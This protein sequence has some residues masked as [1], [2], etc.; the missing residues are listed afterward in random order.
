M[1]QTEQLGIR[2]ETTRIEDAERRARAAEAMTDELQQLSYPQKSTLSD[3]LI[4]L[5]AHSDY[6]DTLDEA[7]R[8]IHWGTH[9]SAENSNADEH[10]SFEN[11]RQAIATRTQTEDEKLKKTEGF[12]RALQTALDEVDTHAVHYVFSSNDHFE[13]V[14]ISAVVKVASELEYEA[15]RW[16]ARK[17]IQTLGTSSKDDVKVPGALYGDEVIKNSEEKVSEHKANMNEKTKDRDEY[18]KQEPVEIP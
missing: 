8:E 12:R 14:L 15:P 11:L 1:H 7:T 16:L 13:E 3:N 17:V 4:E 18:H 9:N 5:T 6:P 2:K 10:H